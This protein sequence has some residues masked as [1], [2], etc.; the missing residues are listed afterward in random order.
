MNRAEVGALRA[1]AEAANAG[2]GWYRGPL[3]IYVMRRDTG[4]LVAEAGDMEEEAVAAGAV[5]EPRGRGAGRLEQYAEHIAAF[6]PP[7][8]LALMD[9]VLLLEQAVSDASDS[10]NGGGTDRER[11]EMADRLTDLLGEG[12]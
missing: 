12:S 4:G 7:T 1:V 5:A 8:V 2:G 9:R 11:F 6:G 3:G 10:L